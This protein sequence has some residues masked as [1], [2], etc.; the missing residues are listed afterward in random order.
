MGHSLIHA[1]EF[2]ILSAIR[3]SKALDESVVKA[4]EELR[5]SST[6]YLRSDEWSVE[7]DLILFRGMVY[8]SNDDNIRRKLVAL[9]HD[10][11]VA[12][13]PGRWKT[14]EL[15]MRNYW[16]PGMTKYIAAYVKGCDPCNRTKVFPQKPV[17]KLMHIPSPS[18]PWKSVGADFITHLPESQGHNVILVVNCRFTKRVHFIVAHDETST[19]G[20]ATL[21][22]YNVWKH[23]GLPDE[24]ISDRGPQFA[25]V[26]MK[27]LNKL[28][29][30]KTKLSTAYHPQT[31]GQTERTNQELEQYLR[32]FINH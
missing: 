1:D 23:H 16:W 2:A 8:I 9:H 6:K 7:Q 19:I 17:R 11:P 13:H 26:L 3:K 21:Y 5:N 12:G 32:I 28:L 31:D 22:R 29:G 4:V 15:V 18:V 14:T 20:L 10:S 24:I 25:S 30:I 27:E